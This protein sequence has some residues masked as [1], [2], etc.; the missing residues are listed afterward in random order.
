MKSLTIVSGKGG[1]GKTS[2]VGSFACLAKN[3]VLADADVDAADLHLIVPP[4]IKKT[5]DFMGGH[6][7]IIDPER[8]TQCGECLDRC[9]YDAIDTDFNIDMIACE[10]CGV[11]AHFCPSSAIDFPQQTC[12]QWF[13]SD[14]AYGPMVHA[15]LGIAEENSGLLVS[16]VRQEAKKIAEKNTYDLIIVDGPP[17]IG[18]PVIAAI[19]GA[20]AMMIITEPTL[21]GMHD[22]KRV[23]E[24]AQFLKVP[25]MLCVNKYDLNPDMTEQIISTGQAYK[26]T[27]VGK[28]PYDPS[29]TQAMVHGVPLINYSDGP[30][31]Q[32]IKDVWKNVS[33]FMQ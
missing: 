5:V 2:I 11:C 19:T 31:S 25:G 26:L 28:I 24:L 8:C 4:T 23:A 29:V 1:T 30:A 32:A 12:G 6:K 10:G 22:L 20:S 7:A 18:C 15:R 3:F 21:S 9:Q 17:G 16:T 14:T 27:A 13:I 33:L